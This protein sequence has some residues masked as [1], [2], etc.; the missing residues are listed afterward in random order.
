MGVKNLMQ[1]LNKN[2]KNSI[3]VSQD[4]SNENS[5][6]LYRSDNKNGIEFTY[7]FWF[8]IENMEYKYG[9]WK[10]IFHKFIFL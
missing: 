1:L 2:A 10:H 3:I 6:M 4:P 9:E 7:S 8:V 5:V